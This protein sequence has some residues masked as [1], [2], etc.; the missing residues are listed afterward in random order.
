MSDDSP[1]TTTR[2]SGLTP[3]GVAA[4][5][6]PWGAS[7]IAPKLAIGIDA[8]RPEKPVENRPLVIRVVARNNS[9]TPVRVSARAAIRNGPVD[10]DSLAVDIA[11]EPFAEAFRDVTLVPPQASLRN[12]LTV[13]LTDTPLADGLET[14]SR[15]AEATANLNIAA[16]Y[17]FELTRLKV[18]RTRSKVTDTVSASSG[19]SWPAHTSQVLCRERNVGGGGT[20]IE[21]VRDPLSPNWFDLY[22]S[23]DDARGV[24]YYAINE[25]GTFGG[26]SYDHDQLAALFAAFMHGAVAWAHLWA[27]YKQKEGPPA[28]PNFEPGTYP[29]LSTSGAWVMDPVGFGIFSAFESFLNTTCDGVVASGAAF[30]TGDYL[31][32]ATQDWNADHEVTVENP[33]LPSPVLCGGDSLYYATWRVARLR[34]PAEDQ[35]LN[36]SR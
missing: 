31:D 21:R 26:R 16:R 28:Y 19:L 6:G 18:S 32:G 7:T 3:E 20:I 22:P 30:L 13:Y 23:P 15:L 1:P 14:S 11:I 17:R 35:Y 12:T 27:S 10:L 34:L 8:L 36:L 5:G 2:T 9:G 29:D 4:A 25:G 24:W 33:G